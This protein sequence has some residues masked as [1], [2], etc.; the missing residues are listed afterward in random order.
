[1]SNTS[2][3]RNV[4]ASSKPNTYLRSIPLHCNT[5]HEVEYNSDDPQAFLSA[6]H[7]YWNKRAIDLSNTFAHR[8]HQPTSKNIVRINL[9]K[10][11][12]GQFGLKYT[13]NLLNLRTSNDKHYAVGAK[14]G[15]FRG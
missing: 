5:D 2:I 7:N 10:E 12:G 6:S 11:Q 3:N 9:L 14:V 4:S 15:Y 1:M 13:D 8:N